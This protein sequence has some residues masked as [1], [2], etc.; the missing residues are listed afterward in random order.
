MK[1]SIQK[2]E[3]AESRVLAFPVGAIIGAAVSP[4]A[5]WAFQLPH[6]KAGLGVT[7][8]FAVIFGFVFAIARPKK[9]EQF[10]AFVV[11]LL[12]P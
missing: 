8:A 5:W 12:N 11:R 1:H 7:V 2:R 6:W 3:A 9:I 4:L 10:V